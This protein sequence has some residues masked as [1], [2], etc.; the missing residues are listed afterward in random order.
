[1]SAGVCARRHTKRVLLPPNTRFPLLL[2][3]TAFYARSAWESPVIPPYSIVYDN[4]GIYYDTTRPSRLE[5]LILAADAMPSE[6]LTQARQEMDFILKHHLSK[7]NHA[8]ELSDNHPLRSPSKSETVLIIDQTFGDMAIQYGGA[9]AS[10][11]ELMFQTALN[12][13]PQA[14]I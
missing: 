10:T 11:F 12:E 5:Q 1:M 8:P 7:Y 14:D 9:D 4:I 2:W 6:T 13:N 3:K